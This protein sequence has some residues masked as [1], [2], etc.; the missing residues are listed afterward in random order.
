MSTT[1]I[2]T[3]MVSPPTVQPDR[4]SAV[5][6]EFEALFSS[7]MFKA[8][9]TT[10]GEGSLLP[11]SMGEKIYT[12]M[13]DDEYA[14]NMSSQGTLGLAALIEK[15][16]RCHEGTTPSVGALKT[17]VWMVDNR[18][19]GGGNP[20]AP[21]RASDIRQLSARVER[22][23]ELIDEAAQNHSVDRNLVAAV[24]A[25]ESA[26]NPYAV[27]R[28]GAKGLMQLMDT[29]AQSLGVTRSYDPRQN[30]NGGVRY[31]RSLLEKYDGNERLALASYNAGP[32][33]VDKY[34]GIPPYRE[35]QQYVRS[36]LDL[37]NRFAVSGE[38]KE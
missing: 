34:R 23:S 30:I 19:M 15:E 9:R 7:M 4:I 3:S 31:L 21:K 5:A 6:R 22:W 18:F 37:R 10:I 26:G 1:S 14:K 32:G 17:P 13:L 27:S 25:Q 29:T 20:V 35:T 24:I 33:A 8:M 36:V 12:S 28:A 2:T 38:Q 16:L 11:E